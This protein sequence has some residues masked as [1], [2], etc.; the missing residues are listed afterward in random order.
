MSVRTESSRRRQSLRSLAAAVSTPTIALAAFGAVV[1][2]SAQAQL[3]TQAEDDVALEEIVVTGSRLA[4][5]SL[6][7]PVPVVALGA[8]RISLSGEVRVGDILRELPGVLPGTNAQ[9]TAASFDQAGLDL[10]DLRGLGTN[11]TLVLFDG[12]RQVGSQ[13]GTVA[14]DLNTVPTPLVERIEVITGGASA[15]YGADAVSGVVNV[16][17]K[18]DFEGFELS[19]SAGLADEGDA[20][21][22]E[23]SATMGGNFGDGR[24]NAV[25]HLNYNKQN[26]IEFDARE[27][28]INGRLWVPNPS[29]TGP[30]DGIDDFVL[31][32]NLRQ[33][34]GQQDSAFFLDQGNG[35]EVFGFNPDGSVRPF[36]LGPSGLLPGNLTDGGDATLGF[37]TICPQNEC[38]VLVPSE[39]WVAHGQADYDVNDHLTAYVMGKFSHVEARNRIGSVFEIPPIT[40]QISIDN[41]FV[42]DDLRTL[43][44]DAGVDSIGILRSDMELGPRGANN[45]RSTFQ[46]MLGGRGDI[47]D[48]WSYDTYFSYGQTQS[49]RTGINDLFQ[50]RFDQALDAVIDPADGEIKCRS[51]VEGT[52][53]DPGCVPVN[54]LA[55]GPALTPEVLEFIEIPFGTQTSELRQT[56][57]H[58]HVT[59]DLVDLWAGPL[60]TVWGIEYRREESDFIT[61]AIQQ[62]GLGFFRSTRRATTG[63][64]DVAEFFAEGQLPLLRDAP[65][66]ESLN[67]E[68]AVRFADYSTS[69]TETSWKFG[70]DWTPVDDIRL[71]V[72]RAKAVRAPNISELFSPGSEG[73]ITVDDPCDVAFVDGG[74]SNRAANC[75]ELG[76]PQNFVSNARTINIRTDSGGNPNLNVEEADTW[77][78]GGVI[79]PRWLPNFSVTAD[80]WRIELSGAI[81]TLDAQ[82]IL[83][84][85]VDSSNVDNQFCNSITRAGNGDLLQIRRN[86]LNLDTLIREGIDLEGRY[87]ASVGD[88][89]LDFT[90][91]TTRLL[92]SE[93]DT[94]SSG[95]S[96]IDDLGEVGD[97]KWRANLNL[98]YRVGGWTINVNERFLSSQQI[99]NQPATPEDNRALAKTGNE[100]FTDLSIRY[101][102][103]S[104]LSATF[105][106]DNV[107]D[108]LPPNL[109]E[110]RTAG[111]GSGSADGATLFDSRGRFVRWGFNLT[112]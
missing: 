38:Q 11:R 39:R 110:T 1:A 74:S 81:D 75:S 80:W 65:F 52:A 108:N 40:N 111:A 88:G 13:P 102:I 84:Q 100:W 53:Q 23:V 45:D 86:N 96:V 28:N 41:P 36:E 30:N 37:D 64:F 32:D 98:I 82:D 105:G 99:E 71:R 21:R 107:F 7:T 97:P 12:R 3:Q 103:T 94:T 91:N 85:C 20:E 72:I 8:E 15:V 33:I 4:R 68:G 112:L 26:S 42:K 106:I 49:K 14:V 77:T 25:M 79:T 89:T 76:V 46:F 6:N 31:M 24:G 48:N 93:R 60:A 51:V 5:S 73:F 90:G 57:G 56:V 10:V 63:G 95:G 43:M 18:D 35:T 16:I 83:N 44:I 29:N 59:G 47:D 22:F 17:M 19:G 69:G 50:N 62:Q 34:G 78:V 87:S 55:S 61:S 67:F 27:R 70:G 58:A 2:S 92:T 54:L 66:A 104:Q 101:Q 9:N 109:P